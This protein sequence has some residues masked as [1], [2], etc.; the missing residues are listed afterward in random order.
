MFAYLIILSTAIAGLLGASLWAAVACSCTLALISI[1]EHGRHKLSS[2]PDLW[3][4]ILGWS[5][6]VSLM[7]S[8]IAG[9][10][11][12]FGGRVLALTFAF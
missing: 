4:A 2:I 9:F 8:G 3:P 5:A 7:N 11:A 6:V 10:A 1:S 12:Y